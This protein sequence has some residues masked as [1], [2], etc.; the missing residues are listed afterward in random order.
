MGVSI[1]S[2]GDSRH[3]LRDHPA[4]R[5]P[6]RQRTTMAMGARG[7]RRRRRMPT[8]WATRSTA[9]LKAGVPHLT[10][11][12]SDV[13]G[14]EINV[15]APACATTLNPDQTGDCPGQ[16]HLYVCDPGLRTANLP[17][18]DPG[19]SGTSNFALLPF[20]TGSALVTNSPPPSGPIATSLVGVSVVPVGLVVDAKGGVFTMDTR[21]GKFLQFAGGT[22][23][24]LPGKLPNGPQQLAIDLAGNVYSTESSSSTLTKLP[25]PGSTCVASAYTVPGVS[26]P[27]S[28]AIDWIL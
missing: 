4:R 23:I 26:T 18:S 28:I 14:A 25:L 8:R 12:C 21:A 5:Q 10:G 16:R 3:R 13:S 27:E 24:T 1:Q 7:T 19:L 11:S 2:K 17:L 22:A 20:A 15:V 6:G 9:P